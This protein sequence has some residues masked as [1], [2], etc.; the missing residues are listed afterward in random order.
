M[1]LYGMVVVTDAVGGTAY[2]G[3]T[4]NSEVP[5]LFSEIDPVQNRSVDTAV[6]TDG[7][8]ETRVWSG[9]PNQCG[10]P[11]SANYLTCY[12]P[13]V[14]YAPLYYM[15]NGVAFDK[16]N[17]SASVFPASPAGGAAGILVRIVNAGLR[18]HIPSIVG[19]LTTPVIVPSGGTATAVPGFGLIAE[20]GNPLPGVTRVQSEVFMAPGKT[21]DVTINAPT[22]T[23]VSPA[24]TCTTLPI[25]DRQGSLSGNA[26]ERDGGMLAYIGVN[27]AGLPSLPTAFTAAPHANADTYNSVIS[28]KTLTVSDPAKGVI[29][30]DVNVSG[31]QL[32]SS[33]AVVG[34]TVTLNR[35]GTFAFA[36]TAGLGSF[37]YCANG[38]GRC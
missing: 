4:Y 36:A 25:F 16:T 20:D 14:N 27:G 28:G 5:L 7:F 21:Y 22:C 1:G 33:V 6:R 37:G 23:P 17:A 34:G 12:P 19:A 31:V 18:S 30:N 2:P 3:V 10:N 32:D 24:T 8:S 9:Q 11:A 38:A 26:T 13:A 35:D 29:A 15:I